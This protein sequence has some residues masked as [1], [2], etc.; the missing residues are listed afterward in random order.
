MGKDIYYHISTGTDFRQ[1]PQKQSCY[2]KV[3]QFL[4]LRV[5]SRINPLITRRQSR[6][7]KRVFLKI[8]ETDSSQEIK[9]VDNTMITFFQN[10]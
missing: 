5:F 7:E 3:T 1:S 8:L 4:F 10:E 6:C 9:S 2:S